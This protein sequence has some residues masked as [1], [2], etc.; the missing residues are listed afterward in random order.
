MCVRR[1]AFDLQIRGLRGKDYRLRRNALGGN[2]DPAKSSYSVAG[3]RV[4]VKLRKAPL[5]DGSTRV[6]G[7]ELPR[8][9]P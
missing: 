8:R 3:G 2:I 7:A 6:G 1:G 9:R 4:V 5:E